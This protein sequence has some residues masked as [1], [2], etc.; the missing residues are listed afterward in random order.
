M[1]DKKIN[2]SYLIIANCLVPTTSVIWISSYTELMRYEKRKKYTFIIIKTI[3][4]LNMENYNQRAN[5]KLTRK[6]LH[7]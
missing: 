5:H 7:H 4:T 2:K 6:L 1:F 3:D